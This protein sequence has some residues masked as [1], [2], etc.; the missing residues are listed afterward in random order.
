MSP[1]QKYDLMGIATLHNPLS[2]VVDTGGRYYVQTDE[3]Y[4]GMP[5]F[6]ETSMESVWLDKPHQ[7][8]APL[9]S[10]GLTCK[11]CGLHSNAIGSDN[12]CPGP[13]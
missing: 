10:H 11:W 6:A 12:P 3:A 1:E 4:Q 13:N 9:T 2:G 8:D 5:L 7:F